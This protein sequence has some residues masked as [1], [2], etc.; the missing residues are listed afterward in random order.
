ME[1]A[2]HGRLAPPGRTSPSH[3]PCVPSTSIVYRR[4]D[5]SPPRL[6]GIRWK[7]ASIDRQLRQVSSLVSVAARRIG[8]LVAPFFD[9]HPAIHPVR[10]AHVFFIEASHA[11]SWRT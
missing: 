3:W 7:T 9:D 10:Y 4:L 8:L 5:A 1:Y 11:R 2:T 6:P